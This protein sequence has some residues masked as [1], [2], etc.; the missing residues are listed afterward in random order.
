MRRF[1]LPAG[2]TVDRYQLVRPIGSG[3][4]G[5]VY[6]ALDA[7]SARRVALK[8][9]HLP[10]ANA[11]DPIKTRFLRE[12]RAAG[13]VAHPHVVTLYEA[14]IEGDIAF[15]AMELVEGE[16]LAAR[17]RR[18]GA[19]GVA[20]TLELLLPILSAVASLHAHGIVHRDIKPGNI[21][22]GEA[23]ASAIT[24]GE[25]RPPA[26]PCVKLADFGL[27]RFIEEPSALT[28]SGMAV[29]TLEYMAPETTRDSRRAGEASDQYSLGVVLYECLTGAKPFGGVTTYDLMEAIHR[30]PIAAPSALEAEV[31]VSVDRIVLRAMN[32][33]PA[34]R[35]DSVA[36]LAEALQPF[37]RCGTSP[38]RA[39]SA[40][41]GV[42]PRRSQVSL[43]SRRA[44]AADLHVGD[45]VAI[46]IHGDLFIV[47][48]KAPATLPR[49]RWT[50]DR[51]DRHAEAH[52]QGTLSLPIVLPTSSAPDG[53]AIGE[54][55]KR[56]RRLQATTR[57][58]SLVA[59]GGGVWRTVV[60]T[61]FRSV[62]KLPVRP[63]TGR[64]TIS[65][66]IDDAIDLVLEKKG[67]STPSRREIADDVRDLYEALDVALS[68]GSS[69]RDIA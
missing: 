13:Q 28:E 33:D 49:I 30:G 27:S 20:A 7:S 29:G 45:G 43:R 4:C 36:D 60:V 32:R 44:G 68:E 57:R 48:W 19:L 18:E 14:G 11:G 52:P 22:L 58:Q 23:S 16:T 42:T 69:R 51:A 15:L 54:T 66:T 21:L 35:F 62:M 55:I 46:A 63:R 59:I 50:F 5:T 40:S 1:Q 34:V 37:A 56:Q 38:G 6:E 47:L 31:P 3:G 9:A 10:E 64:L 67:P 2:V 25:S 39:P 12:V 61:V 53:Q 26:G 17:I 8:L 65:N 24:S 41:A